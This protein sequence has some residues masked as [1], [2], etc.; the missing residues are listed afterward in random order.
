MRVY[1][2]GRVT[3]LPYDQVTAKF[4]RAEALLRASNHNPVNPLKHVNGLASPLEAMKICL[5]LLL[6][7][8]AILL[9]NDYDRSEGAIIEYTLALYVGLHIIDE[10]ELN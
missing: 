1:I 2:A 9:L 10:D 6:D 7:C 5:P 3:G 4:E 8:E